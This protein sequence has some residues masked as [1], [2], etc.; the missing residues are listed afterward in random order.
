MN[1]A[2]GVSGVTIGAMTRYTG[3]VETTQGWMAPSAATP[4]F[5]CTPRR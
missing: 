3:K 1:K 5:F 2:P 4:A